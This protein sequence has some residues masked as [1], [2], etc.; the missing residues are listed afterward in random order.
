MVQNTDV[1]FGATV[2]L[3]LD[4]ANIELIKKL[5]LDPKIRTYM[6]LKTGRVECRDEVVLVALR[7]EDADLVDNII[8]ATNKEEFDTRVAEQLEFKQVHFMKRVAL[9]HARNIT[10]RECSTIWDEHFSYST[11]EIIQATTT[12]RNEFLAMGVAPEQIRMRGVLSD[13]WHQ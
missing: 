8:L 13:W 10:G 9:C 7:D 11:E 6:P 3:D 2:T 1:V 12:A 4:F 5:Y